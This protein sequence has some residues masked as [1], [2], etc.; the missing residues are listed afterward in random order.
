MGRG[1]DYEL[2]GLIT[3]ANFQGIV[4]EKSISFFPDL[5]VNCIA[6]GKSCKSVVEAAPL[7]N[8]GFRLA[9]CKSTL[10]FSPHFISA[11]QRMVIQNSSRGF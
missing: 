5:V 9:C 10:N 2:A 4:P 8:A 6:V 11:Y 3:T 1:L 7:H